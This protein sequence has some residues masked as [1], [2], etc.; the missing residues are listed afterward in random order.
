[1]GK[2]SVRKRYTV[3]KSKLSKIYESLREQIG[4]SAELYKS[5]RVE[6]V[7]TT[8]DAVIYLVDKKPL[9]MDLDGIVFP[10]LRGAIAF[11]FPERRVVVDS[12]AIS[13]MAKGADLMRPG[14]VSLTDDIEKDLPF[15]IV[16]ESYNKPLAIGIASMD[17]A[18][19]ESAEKGKVAKNIHYVGDDIWS[20]E[21]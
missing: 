20:L 1:M 10:T 9:L 16:E 17:G 18:D 7:E 13:F 21:I 5:D 11:P 12:G 2:L 3:R 19:I 6:I 15:V 4:D 8:G 14:I